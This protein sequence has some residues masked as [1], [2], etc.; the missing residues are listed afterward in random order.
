[1]STFDLEKMVGTIDKL[2]TS[3]DVMLCC[4]DSDGGQEILET[5]EQLDNLI[6]SLDDQISILKDALIKEKNARQSVS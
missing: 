1:M 2:G 3:L 6:M 5:C 4:K